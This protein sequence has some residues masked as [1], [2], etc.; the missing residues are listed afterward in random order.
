MNIFSNN[1][2][3]RSYY[4]KEQSPKKHLIRGLRLVE[5]QHLNVKFLNFGPE[6]HFAQL[7]EWLI[8]LAQKSLHPTV[9]I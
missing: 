5:K 1:L 4:F 3:I 8:F 7:A 2:Q 6:N 9:N